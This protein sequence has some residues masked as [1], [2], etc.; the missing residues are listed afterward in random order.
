MRRP[1]QYFRAGVG[2]VITDRRGRVL[3]CER[4][5]IP[6]SWQFPQGGLEKGETPIVAVF[7]EIKE[8]TGFAKSSLRLSRRYPDLLAY[9]LP[10]QA[11]SAKVG[12]G[13]VQYWFLFELKRDAM[14]GDFKSTTEFRAAEWVSFAKAI[15]GV[16][17][18][19]RSVYRKLRICFEDRVSEKTRSS[20]D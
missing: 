17:A 7:R 14:V 16:V 18:F 13:Q 1:A 20:E 8:E 15:R 4:R 10:P 12:L 9:E 6:G 3:V 5:D 2:G 19:K 11:R